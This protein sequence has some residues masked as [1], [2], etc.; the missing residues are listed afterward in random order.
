MKEEAENLGAVMAAAD[1]QD[2]I[3]SIQRVLLEVNIDAIL[4][5]GLAALVDSSRFAG[6]VCVC[7]CVCACVCV[8]VLVC[9][10]VCVCVC[11]CVYAR[12]CVRVCVT[13]PFLQT[14][15]GFTLCLAKCRP[16][17]PCARAL[18]RTSKRRGCRWCRRRQRT[19]CRLGLL[20]QY[21][22]V[23]I[24]L[25]QCFFV[26]IWA[27]NDSEPVGLEEEDG[28][29]GGAGATPDAYNPKTLVFFP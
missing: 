17:P 16:T 12:A 24:W 11:V 9:V 13:P 26:T 8:C 14:C 27:G 7:V 1:T 10:F 2:M 23:T 15:T 25:L 20:L 28:G 6:D 19:R 21:C 3:R 29:C 22:F 18:S 4:S 5:S